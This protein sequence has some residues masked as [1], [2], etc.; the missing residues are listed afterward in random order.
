VLEQLDRLKL[1][2]QFD[3]WIARFDNDGASVRV[4]A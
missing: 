1:R 2:D 4:V 3:T